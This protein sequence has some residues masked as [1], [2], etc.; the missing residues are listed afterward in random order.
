[1]DAIS[2][3]IG[4]AIIEATRRADSMKNSAGAVGGGALGK[5]TAAEMAET[6][7]AFQS[8]GTTTA[9]DRNNRRRRNGDLT[10]GN[11]GTYIRGSHQREGGRDLQ[12][13]PFGGPGD[14]VSKG[15]PP[16]CSGTGR[17]GSRDCAGD[18][19]GNMNEEAIAWNGV[20]FAEARRKMLDPPKVGSLAPSEN[21]DPTPV[22]NF[23]CLSSVSFHM[24]YSILRT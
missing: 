12:R 15:S 1:M 6:A 24:Y 17:G 13:P 21:I 10:V 9:R 11:I 16:A 23:H 20:A 22:C 3:A 4:P 19:G 5:A 14:D 2:S 8:T 18:G 7:A